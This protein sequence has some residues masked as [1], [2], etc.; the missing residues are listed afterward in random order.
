[1]ICLNYPFIQA[2]TIASYPQTCLAPVSSPARVH[3]TPTRGR[4][5]GKGRDMRA[6]VR[7]CMCLAERARDK[8]H[9]SVR[10]E[11]RDP[12]RT[13]R[14]GGLGERRHEA[15]RRRRGAS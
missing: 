2:T 6:R 11:A 1:M 3:E 5:R 4:T 8:G 14:R 9:V 7:G 15:S 12:R 10:D 13:G